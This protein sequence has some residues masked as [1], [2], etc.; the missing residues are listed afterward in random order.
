[1][2]L[3]Q[4]SNS[5]S[6]SQLQ[7]HLPK[8]LAEPSTHLLS[9]QSLRLH[10]NSASINSLPSPPELTGAESASDFLTR[11]KHRQSTLS[12]SSSKQARGGLF[13]L[14]ALARDKTN[15]VI[16]SLSE[17][18]IRSRQSTSSLYRTAQSSPTSPTYSYQHNS[19]SSQGSPGLE[20]HGSGS[21]FDLPRTLTNTSSPSSSRT[22]SV[23]ASNPRQSL[24]ETNPPS[25]AYSDTSSD[26]QPPISFTPHTNANKMHQTSSRLLRMT[27]DDRPYTR[28][29]PVYTPHNWRYINKREG[30]Q[31]FILDFGCQLAFGSSPSTIDQNRPFIRFGGGYQQFGLI[32][33]LSIQSH[34]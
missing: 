8:L 13:S 26:T 7:A 28:V 3:S 4:T 2:A 22:Q 1:M 12:T 18:S 11:S 19:S 16:A 29:C 32:E 5:V 31:G 6:A 14:A 33:I 10:T 30:L 27:E 34:A 25:Q 20:Y 21:T 24:L 23:S 15:N 17:P 9:Q